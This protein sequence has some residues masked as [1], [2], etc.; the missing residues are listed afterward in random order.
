MN[1]SMKTTIPKRKKIVF[2]YE[3]IIPEVRSAGDTLSI[4]GGCNLLLF[5]KN[6]T[7]EGPA[8][9]LGIRHQT[10]ATYKIFL[11]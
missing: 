8:S 11:K 10:A 6:S 3:N 7:K 4:A 2:R 5:N 9:I 1:S